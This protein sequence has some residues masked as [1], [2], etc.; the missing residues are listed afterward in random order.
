MEI[1]KEYLLSEIKN[2]QQQRDHAHNVAVAS[3]AAI[4]VLQSLIVRMETPEPD[5]IKLSDLGLPDPEPITENQD[6][7]STV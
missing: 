2:M 6:V 5:A 1:T 3:Q 4:D 7:N